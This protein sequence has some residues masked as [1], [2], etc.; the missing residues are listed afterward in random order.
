MDLQK[1]RSLTAYAT[2]FM[3]LVLLLMLFPRQSVAV[4]YQSD[5]TT[6]QFKNWYPQFGDVFQTILDVNCTEE[7]ATYMTAVK[8]T[9]KIDWLG[10]G[11][12]ASA[13]TQP[14]I[15]C[16]LD[17]TTDYVKSAMSSAQVLLGVTPTILAILSSSY[18]ELAL[19]N[20][21]AKRPMLSTLLA[22]GSPGLYMSR[23]FEYTDPAQ[24]LQDR[25]GRL[26]QNV[27]KGWK[28]QLLSIA[29]YVVALAAIAN[30]ATINWDLGVKTICPIWSDNVIAPMLWSVLIIVGHLLGS[31][32][33]R[34]QIKRIKL[35][36]KPR[37]SGLILMDWPKKFGRAIYEWSYTEWQS[38]YRQKNIYLVAFG[39]RYTVVIFSWILSTL[40]ILHVIY[41]TI[42]LSSL[43]FIGP[44]D[45]LQVIA[46]YIGSVLACRI[47]CMFEIAGLR[48]NTKEIIFDCD[49][50]ENRFREP[51]QLQIL[52]K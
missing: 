51:A 22:L 27:W 30:I 44:R 32:I 52:P 28:L 35:A 40:I 25:R 2:T 12:R 38:A 19:L 29:E 45:A 18:T 50:P 41:G 42:V 1:S 13:L 3:P 21:V 39:E 9:N 10:G 37:K 5:A 34:M 26:R 20:V 7:Y 6:I 23:A 11:D 48:E 16:L 17:H 8:D 36:K 43:Y 49:A 24:L 33:L 15:Q 4:S 31:F 47:I 14:V 46:R